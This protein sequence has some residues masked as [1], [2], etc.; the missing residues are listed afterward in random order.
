MLYFYSGVD[1]FLGLGG[2][3]NQPNTAQGWVGGEGNVPP[4]TQSA[5]TK[6]FFKIHEV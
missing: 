2:L 4:P 6:I 1:N 5:E 3:I